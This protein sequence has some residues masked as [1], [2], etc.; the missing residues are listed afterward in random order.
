MPNSL[1]LGGLAVAALA[2]LAVQSSVHAV[3]LSNDNTGDVAIIPYIT[4]DSGM[5]TLFTIRNAGED[6]AATR[7]VVRSGDDG[8]PQATAVLFVE[9]GQQVRMVSV[10]F[11]DHDA[12]LVAQTQACILGSVP[13]HGLREIPTSGRMDYAWGEIYEL[14]TLSAAQAEIIQSDCDNAVNQIGESLDPPQGTLAVDTHL[15]DVV[16]GYNLS[17]GTTALKGFGGPTVLESVAVDIPTLNDA[18]PQSTIDGQTLTWSSGA[19]AV[20]S[21]LALSSFSSVFQ[22]E[23]ALAGKT[24]L[25][26]TFPTRHLLLTSSESPFEATDEQGQLLPLT[27]FDRDGVDA[28]EQSTRK[29]SLHSRPYLRRI[30]VLHSAL[31]K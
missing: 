17:I 5:N 10:R 25:V 6:M 14:G 24:D 22:A 29:C 26:L 27:I 13:E 15:I 19:A 2:A 8:A 31:R 16:H 3:E 23:E 7:V 9:P 12:I 4:A 18:L 1:T 20:S 28:S 21:V 11:D 30:W